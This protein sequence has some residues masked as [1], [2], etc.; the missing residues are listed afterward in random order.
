M[1]VIIAL[2]YFFVS[3]YIFTKEK[4][5]IYKKKFAILDEEKLPFWTLSCTRLARHLCHLFCYQVSYFR[6]CLYY[7]E[8]SPRSQRIENLASFLVSFLAKLAEIYLEFYFF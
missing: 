7:V 4:E 8:Y 6:A 5:I 3:L 1:D 2:R